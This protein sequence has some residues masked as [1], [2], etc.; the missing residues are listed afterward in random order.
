VASLGFHQ[1]PFSIDI[2]LLLALF[3][4]FGDVIADV[5]DLLKLLYALDLLDRGADTH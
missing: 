4:H 2:I 3:F 1:E 5:V